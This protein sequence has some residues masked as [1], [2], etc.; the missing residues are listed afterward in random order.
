MC[1]LHVVRTSD[2]NPTANTRLSHGRVGYL[3]C[4]A[5]ILVKKIRLL[6]KKSRKSRGLDPDRDLPK[7][8]LLTKPL[9]HVV[10]VS[11]GNSSKCQL[12]KVFLT[13]KVTSEVVLHDT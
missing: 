13:K 5:L 2:M 1:F 9:A 4:P 8:R 10:M 3:T 12:L 11:R 7:S 6:N